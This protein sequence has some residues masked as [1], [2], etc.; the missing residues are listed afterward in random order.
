M[1]LISTKLE[2]L[3]HCKAFAKDVQEAVH[4]SDHD[5]WCET[6]ARSVDTTLALACPVQ[7]RVRLT[8]FSTSTLP[9]QAAYVPAFTPQLKQGYT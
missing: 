3:Y 1:K 5:G 4:A 7:R 8:I 9:A 6:H 2:I